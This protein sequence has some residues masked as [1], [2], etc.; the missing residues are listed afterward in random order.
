MPKNPLTPLKN[1]KIFV[2]FN[3]AGTAG[4]WSFTRE[5]KKRGYKIDFFG[6]ERP[7]FNFQVDILLKFSANPVKSMFER[8]FYFFKILPQ[9]DVW[10]FNYA[11]TFF[12][13]PLN[14][15]ILRL[16]GKKIICTFRGSDV[17][18]HIDGMPPKHLIRD[19][20][21]ERPELYQELANRSGWAKFQKSLRMRVFCWA[22]D[23]VVLTGPFLAS[24][25]ARF[26]AIIPYGRDIKNIAKFSQENKGKKLTILHAPTVAKTKGTDLV[27]KVFATLRRKFPQH[28]FK[29]L[30]PMPHEEL[31]KTMG[32]A[33]I[34]IDQLLVGWYGGQA[35]EALALGKTVLSYIHP[36]YLELVEFG[37]EIPIINTNSWSL[38]N[39]LETIINSP[40]TRRAL[41]E[42]GPKFARKYHDSAKIADEYLA[43]YEAALLGH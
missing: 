21:F 4:L 27:E 39:D 23:Q 38:E 29:I 22:A 41:A 40:Q 26:D 14:L 16:W 42:K 25:V 13:Y 7:N 24:S 35:V 37:G 28:E 2:G 36:P 20:R 1:K 12:F 33:D 9:Y 43:I 31:L 32:Q 18:N 5:L 6:F 15:L 8:I 34:I 3:F 17:R 30:A 19:P 10:H 11:K